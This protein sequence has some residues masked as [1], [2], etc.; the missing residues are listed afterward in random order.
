MK[1]QIEQIKFIGTKFNTECN[2]NLIKDD[3]R[4][5][6]E[7]TT[8]VRVSMITNIDIDKYRE[9]VKLIEKGRKVYVTIQTE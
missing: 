1:K 5:V 9:L 3:Y 8:E 2:F 7:P 6:N 4:C